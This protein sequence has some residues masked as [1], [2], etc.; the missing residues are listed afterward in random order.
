MFNK[1]VPFLEVYCQKETV[2]MYMRR[3]HIPLKAPSTLNILRGNGLY[4]HRPETTHV[5]V[6]PRGQGLLMY[7][8]RP[9]ESHAKEKH[10]KVNS[11]G[12]K[13]HGKDYGACRPHWRQDARSPW[14]IIGSPSV[15]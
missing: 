2:E 15:S 9:E 1:P 8:Y 7:E 12:A 4:K 11:M 14:Q 6:P 13:R 3:R 10:G 5:Q